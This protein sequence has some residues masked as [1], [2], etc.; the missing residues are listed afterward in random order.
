MS[1]TSTRRVQIKHSCPQGRVAELLRSVHA[2]LQR[3]GLSVSWRG[4]HVVTFTLQLVS[5][6]LEGLVD[7]SRPSVIAI[8]ATGPSLTMLIFARKATQEVERFVK[9]QLGDAFQ[10]LTEVKR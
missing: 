4:A 2:Q 3:D 5:A 6:P 10:G 8:E 9:E 1:S 7:A